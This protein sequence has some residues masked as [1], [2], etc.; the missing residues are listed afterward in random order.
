[1]KAKYQETCLELD[2]CIVDKDGDVYLVYG[3]PSV[4]VC[5]FVH[6]AMELALENG[7]THHEILITKKA[8]KKNG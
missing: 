8:R 6:D 4:A 7:F 2:I 5:D 3:L 1:M